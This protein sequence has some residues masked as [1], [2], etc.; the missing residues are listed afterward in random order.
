MERARQDPDTDR[1]A[2]LAELSRLAAHELRNALSVVYSAVRLL[3][4]E[5]APDERAAVL[6][7]LG[8]EADRM[9]RLAD[10]LSDA[11]RE[12]E[13]ELVALPLHEIVRAAGARAGAALAMELPPP[14][15]TVRGDGPRLE[16]ALAGILACALGAGASLVRVRREVAA[17]G[18][19]VALMLDADSGV[20]GDDLI[21]LRPASGLVPVGRPALAMAVAR[22]SVELM[23]GRL[24]LSRNG[25]GGLRAVVDLPLAGGAGEV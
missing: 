5:Q 10:A 15:V 7:A 18:T 19:R 3:S 24:A 2:T 8:E 20:V 16:S 1:A 13:R 12:D 17:D 22:R 11:A 4:R 23:G 14:V 6:Q 21:A 9:A 25:D